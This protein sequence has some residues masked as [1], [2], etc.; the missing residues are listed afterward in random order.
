MALHVVLA[1]MKSWT[2][3][4]R[5]LINSVTCLKYLTKLV[6]EK[7]LIEFGGYFR[8]CNFVEVLK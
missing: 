8:R 6:S 1:P 5:G 2:L 7:M 4:G 3:I